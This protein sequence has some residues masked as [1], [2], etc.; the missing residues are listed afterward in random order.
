MRQPVYLP[1]NG[2]VNWWQLLHHA[3]RSHRPKGGIENCPSPTWPMWRID[4]GGDCTRVFVGDPCES[5]LSE[6]TKDE[7][8]TLGETGAD[9]DLINVRVDRSYPAQIG[10]Q[11]VPQLRVAAGVAGPE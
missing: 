6:R 10:G 9:H 4:G 1:W 5:V 11:D 7:P 8:E 3:G 2:L